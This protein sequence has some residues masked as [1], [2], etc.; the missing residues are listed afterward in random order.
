MAF[1]DNS[2]DII[3]DAVLT[4]TGRFRLAKGD[5]SFK[6]AKFAFGDDEINYGSYNKNHS[7]GSAYFDLDVL[8]TPVLE[9]FTN[10]TSTMNSKLITIPRTNLLFLPILKLNTVADSNGGAYA[11]VPSHV[12]GTSTTV[13]DGSGSFFVCV[14]EDTEKLYSDIP[15]IMKGATGGNG[16]FARIDQGL[17]TTEIPA[18]FTLDPD[19]RE[20]NYIIQMDNRLGQL[21][22]TDGSAKNPRYIDDDNIAFYYV[23][24]GTDSD[25]VQENSSTDE[26]TD[27]MG[28]VIAGPRGT[29]LH[30]AI[31]SSVE[32]QTST[33]LFGELGGTF[34]LS[35]QPLVGDGATSDVKFIDTI[36]KISGA[37]TGYTIDV[38]VRYIK[39]P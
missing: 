6:I 23:S 1:L 18:S 35:T 7:S 37:T 22:N 16:S 27:A 25:V 21:T 39:Q 34:K 20:T 28:Q 8:Q 38:K 19:L 36:V 11:Q 32:L 17:D 4:D 3:L 26:S 9:A 10:N 13:N 5:G 2:G 31:Q 29:S 14:D 12:A 33:F 30:F 15:G 24:A